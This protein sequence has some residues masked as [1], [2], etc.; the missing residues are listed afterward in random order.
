MH[1]RERGLSRNQPGEH[2]DRK[3]L[4]SRTRRKYIPPVSGSEP[5]AFCYGS[6]SRLTENPEEEV[7]DKSFFLYNCYRNYE[8]K[9]Q[10][11]MKVYSENPNLAYGS[12]V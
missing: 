5:T 8:G 10:D 2:P 1:A 4:A 9:V 11:L 6:P 7:R 3:Q 12:K